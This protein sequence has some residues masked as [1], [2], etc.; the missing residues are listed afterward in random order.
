LR[1][2]YREAGRDSRSIPYIQQNSVVCKIH[3]LFARS[4]SAR[5]VGETNL[6]ASRS[7]GLGSSAQRTNSLA[8]GNAREKQQAPKF[9]NFHWQ[10]GYGGFSVGRSEISRMRNYI[11]T[12]KDHHRKKSFKEE[13]IEF[14]DAYGMTYDEGH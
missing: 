13:L 2:G 10:D 4:G 6:Y 12:Q 11:T 5:F 8:G 1:R 9:N 7:S 3:Y 14:L